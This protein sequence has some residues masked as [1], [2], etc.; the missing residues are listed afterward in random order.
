MGEKL[1][2]LNIHVSGND[3]SLLQKIR[4]RMQTRNPDHGS[5]MLDKTRRSS[6]AGGERASLRAVADKFLQKGTIGDIDGVSEDTINVYAIVPPQELRRI[7]KSEALHVSSTY[8]LTTH[9]WWVD[10]DT[11]QKLH[12]S[13]IVK[14]SLTDKG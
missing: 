13:R 9:R 3:A 14:D 5:V 1:I 7:R 11:R 2:C 12:R 10:P 6:F 4:D 8:D